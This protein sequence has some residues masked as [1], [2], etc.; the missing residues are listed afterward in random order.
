MP[1]FRNR[2]RWAEDAAEGCVWAGVSY[3]ESWL[4]DVNY[5]YTKRAESDIPHKLL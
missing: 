2:N 5:E 3:G 4:A 1:A